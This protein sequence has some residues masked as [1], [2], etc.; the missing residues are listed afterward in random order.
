MTDQD[1]GSG[2]DTAAVFVTEPRPGLRVSGP[3]YVEEG[4]T[5]ALTASVSRDAGADAAKTVWSVARNGQPYASG[6]GATFQLRA[7]DDG[8]SS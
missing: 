8:Q 6:V 1:G 2:T 4:G 7:N 3:D 5:L